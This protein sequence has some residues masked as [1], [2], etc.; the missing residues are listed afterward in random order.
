M[1]KVCTTVR[2]VISFKG[3]TPDSTYS[4]FKLR[5]M[6]KTKW[7]ATNKTNEEE[8]SLRKWN[9]KL[10]RW[11]GGKKTKKQDNGKLSG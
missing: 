7:K 4:R 1:H 2:D 11:R 6:I 10:E 8:L 9:K 5:S 3:A